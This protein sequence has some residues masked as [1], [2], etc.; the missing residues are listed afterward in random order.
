MKVVLVSTNL[1]GGAGG[2]ARRL[3]RGLLDEGI[4][5]TVLARDPDDRLIPKVVRTQDRF[6]T[7]YATARR[8]LD[9]LP[10]L[11]YRD[12]VP[13]R[14]FDLQ[15]LPDRVPAAT[16]RL[17]PDVVNLHWICNAFAGIRSIGTLSAPVVW[18][19]HDMWPMTGGCFYSE[20]CD[21][22]THS[23]GACPVLGSARENDA[24]RA[25]WSRKAKAWK[26][27]DLTLVAPSSWM[28]SCA[29]SSSLFRDRRVER[30]P[31]GHDLK[32][33]EPQ[34]RASARD[35]LGLP[36]DRRLV[37][38]GAWGDP[39][40]KGLELLRSAMASLATDGGDAPELVVFGGAG[41]LDIPGVRTHHLGWIDDERALARVYSAAD[42]TV[43]PSTY[44]TL[45]LIAV[46]S[47]ASGTPVVAFDA[48]TGLPDV[49]DHHENGYLAR[50]FDPQDL[51]AG[52]RWV[53]GSD[54]AR[55][56]TLARNSRAKAEREFSMD[57]QAVRYIA[58]FE[59]LL[60][61]ERPPRNRG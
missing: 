56:A 38:F 3:H 2:A 1:A 12:R 40:R 27:L 13:E 16:A 57:V 50:A 25:T 21:R 32:S 15:R 53:L 7:R 59:E 34:E 45:G 11:L 5:S 28:A 24:S 37:L 6:G 20:D 9:R 35:A 30:I 54:P 29:R 51:A 44:E 60:A 18:T 8:I 26:S 61:T 23:C 49:V 36:R 47:I 52:I 10:K 43:V 22:Y 4:D 58:L 39:R 55:S 46:E 19:L 33:F 17:D 42:V 14:P 31:Y 48:P 41:R